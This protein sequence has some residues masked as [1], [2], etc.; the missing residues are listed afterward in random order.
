LR[1]P[2]GAFSGRSRGGAARRA[3]EPGQPARHDARH[4]AG[5]RHGRL[6]LLLRHLDHQAR[7][8]H[9]EP[10][11]RHHLLAHG[12]SELGRR[13]RRALRRLAHPAGARA[14]AA[15][16]VADESADPERGRGPEHGR[17]YKAP[18]RRGRLLR[19][20]HDRRQRVHQRHDRLGG[21]RHPALRAADFRLRLPAA[22]ARV[23]AHG[24]GVS[25][26]GGRSRARAHH[27]RN[28]PGRSHLVRGRAAVSLSH[29]DGGRRAWRLRC[30]IS[31]FPTAASRFCGTSRSQPGPASSSRC[32][33]PTARANRRSSAACWAF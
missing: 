22:A 32:S 2:A 18:A 3:R 24:R 9:R 20:A 25:H 16:A 28:S 26:A 12:L 23:G 14:A 27:E 11:A 17:R 30:A 5:G 21:A 4:G 33:G 31:A 1:L 13:A 10:A 29:D 8:R 15:A 7:G 19:D 6:A